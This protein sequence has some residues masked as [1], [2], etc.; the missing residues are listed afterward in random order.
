M[1]FAFL[2]HISGI[3]AL[4]AALL[5]LPVEKWQGL[6]TRFVK[7]KAKAIIAAVMAV[8]AFFATPT[9]EVPEVDRFNPNS[10]VV[11]TGGGIE[12]ATLPSTEVTTEP[13]VALERISFLEESYTVG[14]EEQ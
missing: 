13:P 12:L 11:E 8:A 2:P 4:A 14:I 10:A 5:V 3:L 7:E 1:A 9:A 6:V